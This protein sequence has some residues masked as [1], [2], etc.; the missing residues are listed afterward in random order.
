MIVSNLLKVANKGNL[1]R[2]LNRHSFVSPFLTVR[3]C[4]RYFGTKL[5]VDDTM[6]NIDDIFKQMN[7]SASLLEPRIVNQKEDIIYVKNPAQDWAQN[8]VLSIGGGQAA[9]LTLCLQEQQA[10]ALLL[11]QGSGDVRDS[12][13]IEQK[14]SLPVN[15]RWG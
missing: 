10:I 12:Q 5:T 3:P 6:E 11:K 15:L 8:G 4:W 7:R 2:P 13:E 9:A 14:A 1:M